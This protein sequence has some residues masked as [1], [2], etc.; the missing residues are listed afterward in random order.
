VDTVPDPLLPRKSGSSGNRTRD[1]WIC[2][3]EFLPPY[4]IGGRFIYFIFIYLFIYLCYITYYLYIYIY[5]IIKLCVTSRGNTKIAFVY[6]CDVHNRMPNVRMK[7]EKL[8][9]APFSVR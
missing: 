8:S 4:H 3:Q 2:S 5:I 7:I 9:N 6:D 1:P